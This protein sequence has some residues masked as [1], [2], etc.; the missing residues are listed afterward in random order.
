MDYSEY[1]LM[2]K[3]VDIVGTSEHP[4]NKVAA[5]IPGEFH[6][7]ACYSAATNFWPDIIKKKIGRDLK[8]GNASGTVHAETA[9]IME[10]RPHGKPIFVTDVPCPNCIKNMAE[11]GI[12]ALYIDHK[13]FTKD[14]ALRRG[15]HFDNMALRICEKAN[16]GVYKIFRKEKR[17]ETILERREGF[18]PVVEK[19]SCV[20]AV[21]KNV[22]RKKFLSLV[23]EEKEFYE[24]RPFALALEVHI[25]VIKYTISAEA[26]PCPGYTEQ[27]IEQDDEKYSTILQPLNR[28]L[29]RAACNGFKIHPSYVYSSQV[30]TARELVDMVGML[31]VTKLT[32]GDRT[33]CRD[34]GSMEALEQLVN[35]KIIKIMP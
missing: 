14:F 31:G 5:A 25:G 12:R 21:S 30:P 26:H 22:S 4:T 23:E 7:H 35:A 19:P 18:F 15:G 11:V 29:M 13:G 20:S 17:I 28:V 10:G 27:T 1:E 24:G 34:A 32:I 16:I 9:C 3:A 6:G 33:K 2:Q 8:I